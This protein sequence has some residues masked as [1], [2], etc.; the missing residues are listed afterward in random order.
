MK[1]TGCRVQ[2]SGFRSWEAIGKRPLNTFHSSILLALLAAGMMLA[3]TAQGAPG[4]LGMSSAAAGGP[5]Y[6]SQTPN[7]AIDNNTGTFWAPADGA[8]P[9]NWLPAWLIDSSD[10]NR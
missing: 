5:N 6:G 4:W 9:H 7:L 1:K 10:P 3:G 2:G 8:S